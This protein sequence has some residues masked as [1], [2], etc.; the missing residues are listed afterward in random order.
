MPW[1]ILPGDLSL[2]VFAVVLV[3]D[4]ELLGFLRAGSRGEEA[5]KTIA[6]KLRVAIGICVASLVLFFVL[7]EQVE[8]DARDLGRFG[9][10]CSSLIAGEHSAD[11]SL[12]LH[13]LLSERRVLP[14]IGFRFQ[15]RSVEPV[16][17]LPDRQNLLEGGG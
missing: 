14:A 17:L 1:L 10:Q 15:K 13:V 4:G 11:V 6:V 16:D 5:C 12:Q 3:I 9:V 7:D 8:N 2:A